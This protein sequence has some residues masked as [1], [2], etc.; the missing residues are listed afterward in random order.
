MQTPH[1]HITSAL[2]TAH[3]KAQADEAKRAAQATLAQ[4]ARV[5]ASL[6]APRTRTARATSAGR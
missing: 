6:R 3:A 1:A 5:V 2:P 4:R